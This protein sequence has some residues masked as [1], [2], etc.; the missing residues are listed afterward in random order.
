MTNTRSSLVIS[1]VV[2]W[3]LPLHSGAGEASD[4]RQKVVAL[5]A[6]AERK[7]NTNVV[8]HLK[9]TNTGT[10][11]LSIP[12][13]HLPWHRYAMTIAVVQADPYSTPIK[14][15]AV[16]ADPPPADAHRIMKGETLEGEID[17]ADRFPGVVEKLNRGDVIVFWSYHCP[18]DGV[19]IERVVG[20]LVI[21]QAKH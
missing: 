1:A 4:Q 20:S 14:Q 11:T 9:L 17:L 16:I 5:A 2:A 8:L 3:C 13:G 19:P 7:G 12:F 21:S 6:S 15:R 18:A 10:N